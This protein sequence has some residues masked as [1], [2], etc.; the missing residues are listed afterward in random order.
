MPGH[1]GV[2]GNEAGDQAAARAADSIDI[3]Q[4]P[5]QDL[6]PTVLRELWQKECGK[7]ANNRLHLILPRIGRPTTGDKIRALDV[8]RCRLRIGDTY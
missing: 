8:V 2:A 5:Y 7:K 4:V 1:S 3:P 6:K